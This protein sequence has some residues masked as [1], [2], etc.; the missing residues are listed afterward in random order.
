MARNVM[1]NVMST[2]TSSRK[3]TP[4][5]SLA[6]RRFIRHYGLTLSALVV[7]LALLVSSVLRLTQEQNNLLRFSREIFYWNAAQTE[8]ELL[9]FI[10]SLEEY[11]RLAPDTS[12]DDVLERFDI[13]WSRIALYQSGSLKEA[14]REEPSAAIAFT[15]LES[16]MSAIDADVQELDSTDRNDA[17]TY[18]DQLEPLII[19]LHEATIQMM[20]NEAENYGKMRERLFDSYRKSA[21]F[22]AGV[23]VMGGL[24]LFVLFRDNR[25]NWREA[26]KRRAELASSVIVNQCALDGQFIEI[27][28][29]FC[30]LLGYTEQE[31]QAVKFQDITHPDDLAADLLQTER[32][33]RGE[34]PSFTM[35]KRFVHKNGAPIWMNLTCS[36]ATDEYGKPQYLY[37][38]LQ[39]ITARKRAEQQR[40]QSEQRLRDFAEAASDW[41]WETDAKLRFTW[42]SD[43]FNVAT[44]L[45]GSFLIGKTRQ[46]LYNGDPDDPVWRR[47][48]QTLQAHRPFRDFEYQSKRGRWVRISGVPVHNSAGAFQGYRGTGTDITEY[49]AIQRRAEQAQAQ[50][51]QAIEAFP[52]AIAL[53]DKNDCLLVCNNSYR[54]NV[55]GIRELV[56]TG[57]PFEETLRRIVQ[58][59]LIHEAMGR[60]EEWLAYRMSFHRQGKTTWFEACPA[61]D[62][63]I[64]VRE[65]PFP[66]G[67]LII[68]E[69]DISER[70]R[71]ELALRKNEQQMRLLAD[72][73]PVMLIYIDTDERYRFV[74]AGYANFIGLRAEEIIGQKI[75]D[76]A[77]QTLYQQVFKP[78]IDRALAGHSG[79]FEARRSDINSKLMYQQLSYVPHFD[80]DGKVLGYYVMIMDITERKLSE[81]IL[82][83]A[84]EEAE[85]ASRAKSE[86][87][88]KMSH[89]LRTPMNGVLGMTELLHDTA[90]D[91]QQQHF[92]QTIQ[93]SGEALLSIINDVF[94]FTKIEAGRLSLDVSA[95]NLRELAKE[96]VDMLA[97]RVRGK[98]LTL[99]SKSDPF[100]PAV[101]RGDPGRLRQILVN[102]L[103]NAI[104]YT[105][106]G[107]IELRI[108]RPTPQADN[109]LCIRIEVEDTGIGIA[110]DLHE[111][112]FEAFAQADDTHHRQYG[113]TG[114]GLAICRE[115][116]TLMGGEIGV[117]SQPGQG[118]MFWFSVMLDAANAELTPDIALGQ[119]QDITAQVLLAEDNPINQQVARVMLEQIGCKVSLAGDGQAAVSAADTQRFDLIFMDCQMPGMDGYQAARE[120]RRREQAG[121][122]I[123]TPI[124]ALTANVLPD[125][126]R[127]CRSAGMDD[128]LGKPISKQML[129]DTL[130]RWLPEVYASARH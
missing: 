10:N 46:D 92:L 104:T 64:E 53:F 16:T 95:F 26:Q 117:E 81:L 44:G 59:G 55:P 66:D 68:T 107:H 116:V 76:L 19:P 94:D 21:F 78:H 102:L 11:A 126:V 112:I 85:A 101:L 3:L 51:S 4:S 87:L 18:V 63:W 129:R 73:L 47:H 122:T 29:K 84:K 130:Q 115:L 120:I 61:E 105:Q 20:Q 23:V 91:E 31:F 79:V 36:I 88:A 103:S 50:F 111:H 48:L 65:H 124:I 56:K 24:L 93:S 106:Q 109:R 14:L 89:E 108:L 40:K 41:F 82:R 15:D 30:E 110:S 71:I 75:Q 100:V 25:R 128:H 80:D 123:R 118:S 72:N 114:L 2:I 17:Y 54:S 90:L 121:N 42:V 58:K 32:L 8:Y 45:S 28:P 12:H 62:Y 43:Q 60:E 37:A 86:F 70:K 125:D 119:A 74:N 13:L 33:M 22:S 96:V 77:D 38:Y 97:P 1:G 57:A 113:G 67:K 39:D 69:F 52:M 99:R 7:F 34:I 6:M 35:D 127:R 98:K 27:N 83:E 9:R 5:L 49:R